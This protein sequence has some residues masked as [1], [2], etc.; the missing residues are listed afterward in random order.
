MD[1]TFNEEPI[2]P[3]T[4][5][6]EIRR[7]AIIRKGFLLHQASNSH[8]QPQQPPPPPSLEH[9]IRTTRALIATNEEIWAR[10]QPHY[11]GRVGGGEEQHNH[12]PQE[13]PPP[14]HDN[15]KGTWFLFARV[16]ACT[17]TVTT[18]DTHVVDTVMMKTAPEV[19]K[20]EFY[21]PMVVPSKLRRLVP[22]P[23]MGPQDAVPNLRVLIHRA[24]VL[25]EDVMLISLLEY[26]HYLE[27]LQVALGVID[28]WLLEAAKSEQFLK[29][30]FGTSIKNN[31]DQHLQTFSNQ[32]LKV[33]PIYNGLCSRCGKKRN[34]HVLMRS[35]L[36]CS[37]T[38]SDLPFDQQPPPPRAFFPLTVETHLWVGT[39]RGSVNLQF[40]ID[41]PRERKRLTKMLAF[42]ASLSPRS[43][44]DKDEE[45]TYGGGGGAEEPSTGHS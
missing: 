32:L 30:T 23:R 33:D 16:A 40:F 3:R 6:L 2:D 17:V 36:R 38:S 1:E 13:L 9:L 10:C 34:K 18:Y 29:S 43:T 35:W 45:E 11:C 12:H 42:V 7:R 41:E 25:S 24:M 26:K 21:L 27:Q 31:P 8:T 14:H 5:M 19:T 4:F 15:D 22:V 28:A 20:H 39:F 37:E 44:D